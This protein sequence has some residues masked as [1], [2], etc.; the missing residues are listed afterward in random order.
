MARQQV[1]DLRPTGA[2]EIRPETPFEARPFFGRPG[3]DAL[4]V[5][6]F[7]GLSGKLQHVLRQ[8]RT[9]TGTEE[10]EQGA[11]AAREELEALR[12]QRDL[13]AQQWAAAVASGKVEPSASPFFAIARRRVLARGFV[14]RYASAA[15][16]ILRDNQ[17]NAL[18]GEENVS[19]VPSAR[20]PIQ[21]QLTSLWTSMYDEVQKVNPEMAGDF[22]FREESS[23]SRAKVDDVL[24]EAA[25]DMVA[26]AQEHETI[27]AVEVEFSERFLGIT[28]AGT[29]EEIEGAISG[30]TE[31][32]EE[33]VRKGSVPKPVERTLNGL[34]GATTHLANMNRVSGAADALELMDQVAEVKVG[35]QRLQDNAEYQA[36]YTNLLNRADRQERR[37]S[38]EESLERDA[39]IKEWRENPDS[40]YNALLSAPIDSVA[41]ILRTE[42][43]AIRSQGATDPHAAEKLRELQR[44]SS[45]VLASEQVS[46]SRQAA[47]ISERIF[48]GDSSDALLDEIESVR[49][50]EVRLQ[51]RQAK[52]MMDDQVRGMVYGSPVVST[53]R[54]EISSF[55]GDMSDVA[56]TA[57]ATT[58]ADADRRM[59]QLLSDYSRRMVSPDADREALQQEL[60]HEAIP[61]LLEDIRTQGAGLRQRTQAAGEEIMAA[62][63]E[64]EHPQATGLFDKFEDVLDEETKLSY[65]DTFRVV[66]ANR[67][68][69]VDAAD[70]RKAGD[71]LASR[72]ADITKVN[73][74]DGTGIMVDAGL[75]EVTESVDGLGRSI[76]ITDAGKEVIEATLDKTQASMNEFLSTTRGR[77]VLEQPRRQATAE[78]RRMFRTFQDQHFNAEIEART[79]GTI[80]PGSMAFEARRE[81]LQK[82]GDFVSE[83]Y[84]NVPI[85]DL[86]RAVAQE[87]EAPT[88]LSI[89]KRLGA[90]RAASYA[91][92]DAGQ[93]ATFD[94]KITSDELGFD[95]AVEL[96]TLLEVRTADG[97][98]SLVT[99][100][101]DIDRLVLSKGSAHP[102]ALNFAA[103]ALR[104]ENS[105]YAEVVSREAWNLSYTLAKEAAGAA[106]TREQ[107]ASAVLAAF[108]LNVFD[109]DAI[110]DG[111][112][113]KERNVRLGQTPINVPLE[114]GD[115]SPGIHQMFKSEAAM[116][117]FLPNDVSGEHGA[118][119]AA[120]ERRKKFMT[121]LGLDSTDEAV[122]QFKEQQKRLF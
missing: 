92:R 117:Q 8:R 120:A 10:M 113:F 27:K 93:K 31:Y 3:R 90:S 61:A 43:E 46:A 71:E 7:A 79:G 36:I 70:N 24:F 45:L 2:A 97:S 100:S 47:E 44:V 13:S 101:P 19:G 78:L 17:G 64:G 32:R 15:E 16:D 72:I 98:V 58:K 48:L 66:D 38:I 69:V 18:A 83:R 20:P 49:D 119:K 37:A 82:Q 112:L 122:R 91:V 95:A 80:L 77:Q 96:R 21:E 75:A 115:L 76:V 26:A 114:P 62:I 5:D 28:R 63:I 59:N 22:Y 39:A 103:R 107:A 86:D 41:D 1:Q 81:V 51:L 50:P 109:P 65:L 104:K 34:K 87:R 23:K 74:E 54:S 89:G 25:G 99:E 42:S 55:Y 9:I 12:E 102:T 40:G 94:T 116:H 56:P 4:S 14:K 111:Y 84:T 57:L 6:D 53:A 30:I 11:Q 121:N 35:T 67:A 106:E 60:L 88:F 29:P 33:I 118:A 110:L 85:A 105:P 73:A 68:A 108:E 52:D